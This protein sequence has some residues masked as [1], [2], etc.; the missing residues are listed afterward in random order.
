MLAFYLAAME[1]PEDKQFVAQLFDEY[2]Q[3][4]FS[5]AYHILHHTFDAEEAVQNAF[6]N[7]MESNSLKKMQTFDAKNRESYLAMAVKNAALKVYNRRKKNNENSMNEYYIDSNSI[8][9]TEK[10]ALSA[11]SAQEI[12][13]AINELSENDHNILELHYLYGKLYDEIARELGITTDNVRQRIHRAKKRLIK[14]LMERGIHND[15]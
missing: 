2:Q 8:D 4:M 5:I 15:Q 9:T 12:K 7:I 6:V 14:I 1:T 3:M 11:L 13:S 10:E